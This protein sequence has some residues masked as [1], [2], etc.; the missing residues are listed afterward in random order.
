MPAYIMPVGG[1][2][3]EMGLPKFQAVGVLGRIMARCLEKWLICR[4]CGY[5]PP[6]KL[7][8]RQCKV[9]KGQMR[10]DRERNR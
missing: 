3:A 2:A 5:R 10:V 6:K 4:D 9:C 1:F 8:G 7:I